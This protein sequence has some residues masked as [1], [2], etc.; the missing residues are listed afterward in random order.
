MGNDALTTGGGHEEACCP[1]QRVGLVLGPVVAGVVAMGVYAATIMPEV[2]WADSAELA[3]Q[4]VQL[5]VTH[6]PGY[7]VHTGLGK[8][9]TLFFAEPAVGTNWMS[10]VCTAGAV[11]LL[12]AMI[13]RAT[14]SVVACV[15]GPLVFAMS[16]RVWEMAVITEAYNVNILFLAAAL[17]LVLRWSRR[18]T[19]GQLVAAAVCFGVSLGSY[20]ANFLLLPAVVL[21]VFRKGRKRVLC[22]FVFLAVAGLVGAAVLSWSCFR[23]HVHPPLGTRFLPDS[24]QGALRYFSGAQYGTAELRG[25]GFYGSRLAEHG[26]LFA[27]NFLYIGILPGLLG[28]VRHWRTRRD[29]CITLLL[30][31][32]INMGYFTVY[33]ASDYHTMVT[34]SYF[35]FA[36]WIVLGVHW[37][38]EWKPAP[39]MRF[40]SAATV[41]LAAG[42]VWANLPDRL[43]RAKGTPVTDFALASMAKFPTNALVIAGWEKL[44]T[45]L[46]FQTTRGLRPDVTI[47]EREDSPLR[48]AHGT[49]DGYSKY[50]DKVIATR[51]VVIDRIEEPIEGKYAVRPLNENWSQLTPKP[52]PASHGPPR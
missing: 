34:P 41:L 51:P 44:P 16:L 13:A 23:C 27:E 3:L 30:I 32:L 35:V 43:Q 10:A 28:L 4:A 20:L 7:P 12:G 17:W 2:G 8:V 9:F 50:I 26:R 11:V 39:V 33:K 6:P 48:Y 46:Y 21:L 36:Y 1:L 15:F 22:S 18:P 45:L 31:F 42:L 49:I 47:I 38:S 29:E 52:G 14:R 40:V 24:I 5:G 37:L 25:M 19:T